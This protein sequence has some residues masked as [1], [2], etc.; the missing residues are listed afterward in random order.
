MSGK[1][2]FD[3]KPA[4]SKPGNELHCSFCVI[5]PL[6][7][8]RQVMSYTAT[9][10]QLDVLSPKNSFYTW[11]GLQANMH[12]QMSAAEQTEPESSRVV[13]IPFWDLILTSLIMSCDMNEDLGCFPAQTLLY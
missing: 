7:D 2:E 9:P 6:Y 5:V 10:G 13:N 3:V 8:F 4:A 1:V 11:Q 12:M